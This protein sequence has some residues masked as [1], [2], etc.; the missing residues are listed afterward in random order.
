MAEQNFRAAPLQ[1][2]FVSSR[3]GQVFSMLLPHNRGRIAAGRRRF[4]AD[5]PARRLQLAQPSLRATLGEMTRHTSAYGNGGP[6]VWD[7]N[8]GSGRGTF[9]LRVSKSCLL[10][11][12][13]PVVRC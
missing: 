6:I 11:F 9:I 5:P 3:G 2:T 10:H 13:V 1:A 12:S 8:R 7:Q 4:A